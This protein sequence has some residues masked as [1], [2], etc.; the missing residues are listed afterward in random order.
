MTVR[1]LFFRLEIHAPT[2]A[3][4]MF[5]EYEKT[6]V[7]KGCSQKKS[8]SSRQVAAD[9]L[10]PSRRRSAIAVGPPPGSP[11]HHK[12]P[13]PSSFDLAIENYVYSTVLGRIER[14]W[15][16]Q[17]WR[18]ITNIQHP[19]DMVMRRYLQVRFLAIL[20]YPEWLQHPIDIDDPKYADP[21][22]RCAERSM[23]RHTEGCCQ[24]PRV[25][26]TAAQCPRCLC[27]IFTI[28]AFRDHTLHCYAH[29]RRSPQINAHVL[30]EATN[31]ITHE[32]KV[33]G[34]RW[35]SH[36]Y[37][38]WLA[39][40][41]IHMFVSF[42]HS[43]RSLTSSLYLERVCDWEA[44]EDEGLLV[45]P[46]HIQRI[47]GTVVPLLT[48]QYAAVAGNRYEWEV[49]Y[50]YEFPPRFRDGVSYRTPLDPQRPQLGELEPYTQ[51][52]RLPELASLSL[53]DIEMIYGER[54]FAYQKQ[55][56][57]SQKVW[58]PAMGHKIDDSEVKKSAQAREAVASGQKFTTEQLATALGKTSQE[59]H[60]V[61]TM[62]AR[63]ETNTSST[64][65]APAFIQSPSRSTRFPELIP[66]ELPKEKPHKRRDSLLSLEE[67]ARRQ[68]E[69]QQEEEKEAQREAQC[70]SSSAAA[71]ASTVTDA[72]AL[73]DSSAQQSN[74]A[75]QSQENLVAA[76]L[77]SSTERESSDLSDLALETHTDTA[78][79][80][81]DSLFATEYMAT[82][83]A[84]TSESSSRETTRPASPTTAT[85]VSS[86]TAQEQQ[87]TE[88]PASPKN[89]TPR[90]RSVSP[91]AK[92]EASRI[93]CRTPPL[94]AI[95][96]REDTRRSSL[97]SKRDDNALTIAITS[98]SEDTGKD[99]KDEAVITPP[100]TLKSV[101]ASLLASCSPAVSKSGTRTPTKS[102]SASPAAKRQASP[103]LVPP[104]KREEL[105][106]PEQEMST[107]ATASALNDPVSDD[108]PDHCS[109]GTPVLD[110]EPSNAR[111]QEEVDI[112]KAFA[113]SYLVQR[114]KD[115]LS[116]DD[117]ASD[118]SRRE[119]SSSVGNV[120]T[121]D[122]TETHASTEDAAG[123]SPVIAKLAA[124]SG[125]DDVPPTAA[126]HTPCI[127]DV[128]KT[129]SL[130]GSLE[131][132]FAGGS[133]PST[134]I[135]RM[136]DLSIPSLSMRRRYRG[137]L[138]LPWGRQPVGPHDEKI[139]RRPGFAVVNTFH[140][141]D[142]PVY[143][144]FMVKARL[145]VVV[146]NVGIFGRLSPG[147]QRVLY[148]VDGVTEGYYATRG[149]EPPVS[150]VGAPTVVTLQ[151]NA[152]GQA[153]AGQ[154]FIARCVH[155]YKKIALMGEFQTA[156]MAECQ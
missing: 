117:T 145:M 75:T 68:Q 44:I 98:L 101:A 7:E 131:D 136:P 128:P 49:C 89:S 9:R 61:S 47:L 42:T 97:P 90:A 17:R 39:H 79:F 96:A 70:S 133:E 107:A 155:R 99:R 66:I 147:E 143:L 139:L 115:G 62:Q 6:A 116:S 19:V 105:F 32:C 73:K 112:T 71:T 144:G 122:K 77:D 119:S 29:G 26:K 135:Y 100:L 63:R 28:Q 87:P 88:F 149:T 93:K 84:S 33:A 108:V 36:I 11:V 21:C 123:I 22:A 13:T 14:G 55:Q 120:T 48:G 114:E 85:L 12:R 72:I 127:D 134:P 10:K 35:S 65:F 53:I 24:A 80:A 60:G 67:L 151:Y 59:G 102:L 106:R 27:T 154:L 121:G 43:S 130:S 69:L 20:Q 129:P 110:E 92:N 51:I 38:I 103:S 81:E 23:G 40:T 118:S 8:S 125:N 91:S 16:P 5:S 126:D 146:K 138:A 150:F 1:V 64:I 156:I 111:A 31:I 86:Q 56:Q 140:R 34:C 58:N 54:L 113:F 141:D 142:C 78:F 148:G 18:Q 15:E 50:F 41:T 153:Q 46:L 57:Q 95:A 2:D 137:Q 52:V 30:A 3:D 152:A 83:S 124:L 76:L 4:D 25:N 45:P 82:V 132:L 104:A 74:A 109:A 94:P 37:S